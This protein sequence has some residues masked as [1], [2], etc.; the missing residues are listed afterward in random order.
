MLSDN[1]HQFFDEN[2]AEIFSTI[3]PAIK[4]GFSQVFLDV[5]NHFLEKIPYNAVIT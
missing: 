1:I 3:K 5:C 4:E 2:W